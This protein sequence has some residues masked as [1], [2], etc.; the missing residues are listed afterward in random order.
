VVRGDG[1]RDRLSRNTRVGNGGGFYQSQE[2]RR[3][4]EGANTSEPTQEV[5][6]FGEKLEFLTKRHPSRMSILSKIGVQ[7]LEKRRQS[8]GSH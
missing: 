2:G 3:V 6:V 4:P 7:F 1:L 5:K 8:R